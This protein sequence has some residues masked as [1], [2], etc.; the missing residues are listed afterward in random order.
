[1]SE[2]LDKAVDLLW[3]LAYIKSKSGACIG[4]I[5]N[6]R[7]LN[8]NWRSKMRGK[9]RLGIIG[10]GWAGRE[11]LKGYI[12]CENSEPV[13]LCDI[14]EDLLNEVAETYNVRKTYTD[15]G[16][17]LADDEIDAVSVCLPNHLH[18]PATV[19]SLDAGKHVICEKPPALNGDEAQLMV[20]KAK[21]NGKV[22]MYAMVMRFSNSTKYVK[23]LA[24][25][26][27]F[28]EIYLGKA[29]YVRRRGIP[30]GKKGWFV[31]KSRSGG[32][33]LIDIGVHALDCV[34]YLMGNPKPISV[35]GSAY[36]RFGHTVPKGVKY[37]VDDSAFGFIKFENG[38]TLYIE[39]TWALNQPEG[40]TKLLA[41][42][43]GGARLDPLT[44]YTE[45]DG[46]QLD[47]T[48]TVKDQNP[49]E[50]EICHFVECILKKKEPIASAIQGITLM[51]MLDAIYESAQTG[52][53][54]LMG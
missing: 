14:D 11:H 8:P 5:G 27:D 4:P 23:K 17:L 7:F 20:D 18:C 22:L 30:I 13:A 45:R 40:A 16:K 25:K 12:K 49:F 39:S 19:E 44:I 29:G 46:V 48:P 2:P 51:R 3:E 15:Y 41:G 36:S 28:G 43:K 32:G 21:S 6:L 9:V 26:G 1:M 37:D 38:A 34:W 47:I 54:V 24:E 35:S 52:R 50:S 53:E 33:A 42:T 10:L 31:D